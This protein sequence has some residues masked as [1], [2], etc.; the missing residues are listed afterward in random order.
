MDQM[1][2]MNSNEFETLYSSEKQW[3]AVM[4]H[5]IAAIK[6]LRFVT[7]PEL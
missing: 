2:R 7:P 4:G 3:K 5:Q 6:L 1:N